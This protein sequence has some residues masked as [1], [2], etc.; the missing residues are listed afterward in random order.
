MLTKAPVVESVTLLSLPSEL[1]LQIFDKLDD[2]SSTCFGLTNKYFYGTHWSI[3]GVMR[4]T[5]PEHQRVL[6]PPKHPG[7]PSLWDLIHS[8]SL[9]ASYKWCNE[10]KMFSQFPSGWTTEYINKLVPERHWD[11]SFSDACAKAEVANDKCEKAYITV[12]GLWGRP[13]QRKEN[14]H[15]AFIA[16]VDWEAVSPLKPPSFL[17]F[18]EWQCRIWD[19]TRHCCTKCGAL[20]L[21]KGSFHHL[22]GNIC[23]VGERVSDY[24]SY[25]ARLYGVTTWTRPT[26]TWFKSARWRPGLEPTWI[27]AIMPETEGAEA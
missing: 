23:F 22:D 14:F 1:H 3:H 19:L 5:F 7:P 10:C 21:T 13:F 20:K 24:E 16:A 27:K 8:S 26:R 15:K 6:F 18:Q 12:M 9:F 17:E 4:F 11:T 2:V 25:C